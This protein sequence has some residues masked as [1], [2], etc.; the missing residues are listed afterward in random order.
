[1][2]YLLW[3]RDL[4]VFAV[5]PAFLELARALPPERVEIRSW[6]DREGDPTFVSVRIAGP[7]EIVY[8]GA[9]AARPFEVTL[10]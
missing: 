2:R 10:H 6:P 4:A 3:E 1:V 5:G 7:H 8:R 9:R